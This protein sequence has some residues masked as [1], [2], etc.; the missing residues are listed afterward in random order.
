MLYDSNE[1]RS[2][3]VEL[4]SRITNAEKITTSLMALPGSQTRRLTE[5]DVAIVK[6]LSGDARKPSASVAK[7]L[8]LSSR[9]VRNRVKKLRRENTLFALPNLNLDGIAG[10]IPVYLSYVYAN[11]GAKG[12]VDRSILEHFDS[13]YLWGGFSDREHAFVVL[14]VSRMADVQVIKDW[15]REQPGVDF[16]EVDML[17]ELTYLPQMFK[18]LLSPKRLE[19]VA[20]IV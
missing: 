8:G 14:S 18:E 11:E 13:N 9:T 4:I 3:A 6:A 1:S 15:A 20:Y 5:T 19:A 17:T 10:S 16:A 2:N 7:N 12:S